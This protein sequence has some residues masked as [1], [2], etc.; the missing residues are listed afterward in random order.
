MVCAR[1]SG[2]NSTIEGGLDAS[3]NSSMQPMVETFHGRRKQFCFADDAI[4]LKSAIGYTRR[5]AKRSTLEL[6]VT[7]KLERAI[8]SCLAQRGVLPGDTNSHESDIGE[9]LASMMGST[10]LQESSQSSTEAISMVS[11]VQ[12]SSSTSAYTP[13]W[14]PMASE[15]PIPTMTC[16]HSKIPSCNREEDQEIAEEDVDCG[17]WWKQTFEDTVTEYVF[18]TA[19]AGASLTPIPIPRFGKR[20]SRTVALHRIADQVA[21]TEGAAMLSLIHCSL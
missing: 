15:V 12:S 21:S 7:H 5:H 1:S 18:S 9:E 20:R 10:I 8:S 16:M 17:I 2:H 13:E 19:D 6:E 3:P 4:Q 14:V 11:N